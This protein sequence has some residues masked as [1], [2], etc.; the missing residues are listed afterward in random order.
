M[1]LFSLFQIFLEG[2]WHTP[3]IR[4]SGVYLL[5]EE[6]VPVW[7]ALAEGRG[8][9]ETKGGRRVE[10][11]SGGRGRVQPEERAGVSHESRR[12]VEHLATSRSRT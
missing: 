3:L 12:G 2:P 8:S 11:G 10:L 6:G 5:D 9:H 1:H 4:S 7:L